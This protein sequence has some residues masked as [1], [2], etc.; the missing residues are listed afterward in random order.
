MKKKL[1]MLPLLFL[2]VFTSFN[3]F[4]RGGI[5]A[6]DTGKKLQV[7]STQ[8]FKIIYTE[9]TEQNAAVLYANAD[10]IYQELADM[11]LWEEPPC[12]LPVVLTSNVELYNAYFNMTPYN[13]IVLY[14]APPM[15]DLY[16]D[17]DIFLDCFKHELTHC[18]TFNMKNGFWRTVDTILGEYLYP[19]MLTI[20]PGM[21][22]G[23]TLTSESV[24]GY[25]R[26]ND[27]FSHQSV[28]QAKIEGKFPEF[29]D[30]QGANDWG[31]SLNYYYYNGAF[32]QYLQDKYG[33]EKYS[34]WWYNCVNNSITIS[35][36]FKKA[37]GFS[38]KNAWNDFKHEYPVPQVAENP[39]LA[40]EAKDFFDKNA[41]R[42]SKKNHSGLSLS[43]LSYS[44]KGLTYLDEGASAV[45]FISKDEIN[46]QIPK[47]QKLF[48]WNNIEKAVQS[49]DGKYI[50]FTGYDLSAANY[51]YYVKIYN[52]ESK[53]FLSLKGHGYK[54]ASIVKKGDKYYLLTLKFKGEDERICITEFTDAG[55]G[56]S[57]EIQFPR[58][59][60]PFDFV[61]VADGQ[62]A[63]I[64]LSRMS[65]AV[66]IADVDGNVL[67]SYES[68]APIRGLSYDSASDILYFAYTEKNTM[69]RLGSLNLSSSTFRFTE[70]DF[71]GGVWNPLV[72]ENEAIYAGHFFNEDRLL[73]KSLD[74][75]T[76]KAEVA[77]EENVLNENEIAL[78]EEE[79]KWLEDFK[80]V[81]K[82]NY[83]IFNTPKGMIFPFC[84]LNSNS[85]DKKHSGATFSLPYGLTYITS[86]PWAS[87]E[88][89]ITAG[90]GWQTDS[91]GIGMSYTAACDTGL[92][93]YSISGQ[94]EFDSDGFKSTEGQIQLQLA[95]SFASRSAFV[96]SPAVLAH[97]GRSNALPEEY[98]PA[99]SPLSLEMPKLEK[100]FGKTSDMNNYFYFQ[101]TAP[102]YYH[103]IV[104]TRAARYGKSGFLLGFTPLYIYSSNV[105]E[106]IEEFSNF[107]I[108]VFMEVY[109]PHLLPVDC[110]LGYTYN[111]PTKFV[112]QAF[113]TN[114]MGTS[115][116]SIPLMP[117]LAYIYG[118]TVLVA[119]EVQKS[120]PVFSF[121]YL[122]DYSLSLAGFYGY[123]YNEKRDYTNTFADF[124]TYISDIQN[125]DI[126]PRA[127]LQL[128]LSLGF[129]PLNF[130]MLNGNMNL[131]ASY[132]IEL[133]N[134][135]INPAGHLYIDVAF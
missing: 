17:Y 44:E 64:L 37:Y 18:F 93:I 57:K 121:F 9:S 33:M 4:A 41:I 16:V 82:H 72:A 13:R 40:K 130:G 32:H 47:A 12:K 81:E 74:T 50:A 97:Y 85:Y 134:E 29:K 30:V 56:S 99:N 58:V 65:F 104:K 90:Y 54:D 53:K 69:P 98:M 128:K 127:E 26:M 7:V 76:Y 52:T 63:Y 48:R 102:V 42:Y 22:E 77:A 113:N 112:F 103:N 114:V 91:Y 107:D 38:I 123:G 25:G 118:E 96:F 75:F 35:G 115:F 34:D 68:P 59:D 73:I 43:S 51:R 131:S 89:A 119:G 6:E 8:W 20:S 120:L 101:A 28:R 108:S 86:N 88:L 109:I 124:G 133:K 61:Q 27:E 106:N 14:V 87:N 62:F 135:K 49:S 3:A 122:N 95:K 94:G 15:E 60:L 21:A 117:E 5:M 92:Y 70:N 31:S 45:Y 55:F 11:Y 110:S 23:A 67:R 105:T 80:S 111:L 19:G 71:S 132:G 39:V 100:G 1:K 129:N 66:C 125:G 79:A 10:R 36:A 78:N 83:N 116:V 2:A 126:L 24:T 46:N 84:Q